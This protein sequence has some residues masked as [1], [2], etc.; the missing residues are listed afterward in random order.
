MTR[1]PVPPVKDTV[2]FFLFLG[3]WALPML[4]AGVVHKPVRHM[5]KLL[6]HLQDTAYLFPRGVKDAYF[7]YDKADIRPDQVSK[8]Q[9]NAQW[10]RDNANVRLTIEGHCD[11]RG[12]EEYNIGLGDRRANAVKEFLV[13]QGLPVARVNTI[14]YGEE[15]PQCRDATEDCY[16]KNRRAAFTMNR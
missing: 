7:D 12:S 8:L 1:A 11:E 4:Y 3:L 2:C 6:R 16:Q 13:S 9:S 14:S 5:P 10:L 15:R